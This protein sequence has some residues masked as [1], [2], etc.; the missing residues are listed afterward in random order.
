M[1]LSIFKENPF[2]SISPEMEL[3]VNICIPPQERWDEKDFQK[4]SPKIGCLKYVSD[5]YVGDIKLM[6][7]V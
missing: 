6:I 3:F 4:I 7:K 1:K 2:S 5:M